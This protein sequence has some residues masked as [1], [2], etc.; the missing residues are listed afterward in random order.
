[1]LTLVLFL[2]KGCSSQVDLIHFEVKKIEIQKV[3]YN[4]TYWNS[5]KVIETEETIL[6]VIESINE[7]DEF[8]KDRLTK[9][10]PALY[11]VILNDSLELGF[12]PDQRIFFIKNDFYQ[13]PKPLKILENVSGDGVLKE[14]IEQGKKINDNILEGTWFNNSLLEN[15]SKTK[16][17]YDEMDNLQYYPLVSF[18]FTSDTLNLF[19]GSLTEGAL[20]FFIVDSLFVRNDRKCLRLNDYN[21]TELCYKNNQ[22]LLKDN[23][24]S[25]EFEYIKIANIYQDYD[26]L[27]QNLFC[28]QLFEGNYLDLVSKDTVII[29]K[30]KIHLSNYNI[31]DFKIGLEFHTI[32]FDY[33]EIIEPGHGYNEYFHYKFNDNVLN[34]KQLEYDKNEDNYK[35]TNKKSL[36]LLKITN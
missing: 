7:A 10:P 20:S 34:L 6:G 1:M 15:I 35:I 4:G 21:L 14:M 17:I 29:S 33:I 3:D 26:S 18:H 27:L 19:Y 32:S 9:Y 36:K 8:K 16:S 5:L 13:L 23:S 24:I 2:L 25:K 22:L 31:R 28:M 30:N 12:L 11:K